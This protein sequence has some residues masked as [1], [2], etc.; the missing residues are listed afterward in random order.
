VREAQR[1]QPGIGEARA[2]VLGRDGRQFLDVAAFDDPG[3]T[4]RRKALV[5]IDSG[6]GV[7]VGA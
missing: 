3:T 1:V 5:E 2:P 6:V 7:G 4:Q